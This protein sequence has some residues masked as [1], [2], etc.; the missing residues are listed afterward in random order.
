[1]IQESKDLLKTEL[2]SILFVL[3]LISIAFCLF[4][5]S[6]TTKYEKV[7]IPVPKECEYNLTKQ[8]E[9]RN[10]NLKEI[11]ETITELSLDSKQI[12]QDINDIPCIIVK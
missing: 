10:G 2:T 9:I 1:M 3:C 11:L 8:P 5:C 4:G 7:N 12:R 6:T